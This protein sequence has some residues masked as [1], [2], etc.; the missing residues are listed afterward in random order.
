MDLY[1]EKMHIVERGILRDI[2]MVIHR[3]YINFIWVDQPIKFMRPVNIIGEIEQVY[4][5]TMESSI[6]NGSEKP[7]FRYIALELNK[8]FV[9]RVGRNRSH[10]IL[11]QHQ[12]I[13]F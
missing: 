7:V 12:L 2:I 13:S 6:D 10:I 1:T 5:C 9:Q 11:V 4:M 3:N 8:E